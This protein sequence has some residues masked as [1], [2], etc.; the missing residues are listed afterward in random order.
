MGGR[1]LC[2]YYCYGD[3]D[4]VCISEYPDNVA[5][6]AGI[7]AIVTAGHLKSVKTTVLVG[8]DE[9]VLAMKKQ[10]ISAIKR[11]SDTVS[12]RGHYIRC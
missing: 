2:L 8:V 4:G 10:R 1:L 7:L 12:L 3:F 6:V 5:N 11:Q 9:A